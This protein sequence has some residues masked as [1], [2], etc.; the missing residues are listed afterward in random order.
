MDKH[1][2]RNGK[3]KYGIY[4]DLVKHGKPLGNQENFHLREFFPEAIYFISFIVRCYI[5]NIIWGEGGIRIRGLILNLRKLVIGTRICIFLLFSV[6][7]IL[8]YA[9]NSLS[10]Y[11]LLSFIL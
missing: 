4:V 2:F 3:R 11:L 1:G 6:W 5:E 8:Q 9:M 10:S 7:P